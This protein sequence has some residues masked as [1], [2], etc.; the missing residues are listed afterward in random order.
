[1]SS[2]SPVVTPTPTSAPYA[3]NGPNI[4][5]WSTQDTVQS[6]SYSYTGVRLVTVL[7]G[8]QP[9]GVSGTYGVGALALVAGL[10][11]L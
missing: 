8:A 4:G 5:I 6:G 10:L 1:M 2:T 9:T 11:A 3:G 7:S